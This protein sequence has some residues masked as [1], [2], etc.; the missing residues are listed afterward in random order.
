[1]QDKI[2]VHKDILENEIDRLSAEAGISRLLAKVFVNRGFLDAGYVRNFLNPSLDGL[3][4]PFLLKDMDTAVCR[5]MQA[6]ECSERIVIYGDYDVDGVTSTSM[7]YNFLV[8]CGASV[9]F[10]IPDR[11]DEGYGL[12]INAIDRAVQNGASLLITVDCGITACDE[13]SY[14]NS[15]NI[16]VIITDHHECKSIL[17]GAYAVI[18]PCRPDCNYPFKEL[19]GVGVVFKLV[20][21]LC[22]KMKIGDVHM[23][24]LDLA[25][26]GTVADVVPLTDENRIIVKYGLPAMEKSL[27]PGIKALIA[28]SGLKDKQVTSYGAGFA[29]APRIN[30]AGRIGN[31]ARAVKL[32]TIADEKLAD[33][34]AAELNEEN[35]YRQETE[36]GIIQQ[37]NSLVETGI[38]LEKEK[39]IIVAGKEWHHG[40]IGIVASK[41][42]EKYHRPCI[43]LCEEKGLCKGS[44][45]SIEGFNLF[46]ALMHCENLLEKFGGHEM[47]AGLSLKTENLDEFKKLINK[48]ADSVLTD[49]DLIPCIQV[50]A[51]AVK[52]DITLEN[53]RELELLAPFG[54]GNPGPVFA[55]DGLRIAEIRT[56]GENKHLKLKLEDK[57]L[58]IDAIGFN[59][60]DQSNRYSY[61]NT[62]DS[63]FTME[64]NIWNNLQKIQINL[65]DIRPHKDI[66]FDEP[67]DY[68]INKEIIPDRTDLAAVYQHIRAYCKN[69]PVIKPEA[70][71]NV[72]NMLTL[73]TVI[74]ERYKVCMNRDKL[75]KCI[76]I[77]EE[78]NL[79]KKEPLGE[80]GMIITL[81]EAVGKTNL[82]DSSIYRKL[83]ESKNGK[84]E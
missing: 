80:N 54:S 57:G 37:V 16:Q 21:A 31:A 61:S 35:R 32:F 39:V 28:V 51:F 67:N 75:G 10:Y 14:I 48:Y 18:N 5:I 65:K 15:L 7:L 3:H 73:A 59:M 56:V 6:V 43:L 40:I 12:S 45:R 9:E 1:M 66:V 17:P 44:G 72:E 47:A 78:L 29:L 77:F 63:V 20:H 74:A 49:T 52:E 64:I 19:A 84:L 62:V 53:I 83:R 60:G 8:S 69:Q 22:L 25:A 50:D 23:G 27:N 2:W 41:I 33:E 34:I 13:V 71:M 38:D 58:N 30:A 76:E 26:L 82:E 42:T 11:I 36:S 46:S 68:N 79:L 81:V 55:Y 4:D 24:Y 70:G